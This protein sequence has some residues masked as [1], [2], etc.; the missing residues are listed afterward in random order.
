MKLLYIGKV[1]MS[2]TFG[3]R[4]ISYFSY[5]PD[6]KTCKVNHSGWTEMPR[7]VVT[8]AVPKEMSFE[9]PVLEEFMIKELKDCL[10]DNKIGK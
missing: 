8:V 9:A 4:F 6:K 2:N 5:A 10:P 3:G 1:S 7:Y